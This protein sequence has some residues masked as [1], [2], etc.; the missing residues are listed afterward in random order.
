MDVVS[1]WFGEIVSQLPGYEPR[2]QQ[3]EMARVIH[4]AI[5]ER[6]HALIEAGTG[7]GKSFAY[8]IPLLQSNKRVVVSTGTIAL[9]E[10]LLHKDIPFLLQAIGRPVNVALAKG[11]G[12]YLCLRKLEEAERAVLPGSSDLLQIRMV[13][14]HAMETHWQGD[15]SELPFSVP[16]SLWRDL[17]ASDPQ[18]CLGPRCP[19]FT[20]SPHKV[21][22]DHVES[23]QLIVANHALYFSDLA[24]GGGLLPEHDIVVFDEAHH[25]DRAAASALTIQVDRWLSN[26]LL[27]RVQRRFK[28]VPPALID[29]IMRSE[30]DLL[31]YLFSRGRGQFKLEPDAAFRERVL[32]LWNRLTQL[33]QWLEK[34]SSEQ[35]VL[36]EGETDA[37]R[38]RA[39]LMREQMQAVAAGI[40][41]RWKHFAELEFD[42][43][44]ANWMTV[45]PGR[46]SYEINSAPLDVAEPLRELLWKK[47]TAVLTSATLAVDKKFSFL[48]SELGLPPN[49]LEAVLGSPF[50]FPRQAA[51][52]VPQTGPMPDSA[53]YSLEMADEVERIL[54][55]TRG[56]AFVLCTSY[57]GLR[58]LH[59]TLLPRLRYPTKTQEELPRSRLIEWF[60]TTPNAV[61]FATSTFWE[62]VDIPGETLSCVIIDKLPFSNP[63][64]PVIQARTDLM[65]SRGEDWF[66]GFVLPRAVLTLKQGFGR[67]IRTRTDSGL[68]AILD[69]RLL[70]KGYGSVMLRSL[71]PARRVT[72]LL[73]TLEELLTAPLPVK[74]LQEAGYSGWMNAPP[75]DLESVLGPPRDD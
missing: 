73:P 8:L 29:E 62:G 11:R 5:T 13:R 44:R 60:K 33:A 55:V 69:R 35:M 72:S 71:P 59:Q 23:A 46:D 27:Q 74:L 53:T 28:S 70:T 43:H 1:Q 15:R 21:A 31:D 18:D 4:R 12:N 7:S 61:L 68:V 47:R 36:L 19:N 38:G 6:R 49:C 66:N 50:D 24:M 65:R 54:D 63:D 57:R 9:Q 64:D 30:S 14:E 67:L 52:Y 17:L 16:N 42:G 2:P 20:H 37:E 26:R 41:S 32:E 25:L 39:E 56:R 51:L 22:R 10:Q 40:A 45:D 75:H 3:V 58:E 48:R 34:S